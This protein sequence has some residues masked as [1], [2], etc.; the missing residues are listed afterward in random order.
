MLQGLALVI[1][2]RNKVYGVQTSGTLFIFW[3]LCTVCGISRFR[4]QIR[5]A[6]SGEPLPDYYEYLSYMMYYPLVV[7]M[8]LLNCLAEGLPKVYPYGKFEVSLST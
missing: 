6:Q 4:S 5:L 8:L 7:A 2:Y 3:F 1:A